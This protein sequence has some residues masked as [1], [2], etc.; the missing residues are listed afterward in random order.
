MILV[1]NVY[2]A[3]TLKIGII[4]SDKGD[5][6]QFDTIHLKA[7]QLAVDNIN[8]KG[9]VKNQQIEIIKFFN[10]STSIGAKSAAIRA[11]EENILV[12]IGP[13]WSSHA[14]AAAKIFQKAKIPMITPLASNSAVTE[15]G[16]YIFRVCFTDNFQSKALASFVKDDIRID[17]IVILTNL[18]S[19]YSVGLSKS[20]RNWF[21]KFGGIIDAEI[22]YVHGVTNYYKLAKQLKIINAKAIFLPGYPLDSSSIINE[23]RKIGVK[24]I[25]I[26]S[27]GWGDI[28]EF[29]SGKKINGSYYSGSWHPSINSPESNEFVRLYKAKYGDFTS[30]GVALYYDTINIILKAIEMSRVVDSV[31]IKSSLNRITNYKGVTGNISFD[32]N[33]NTANSIAIFQFLEGKSIFLK[34]IKP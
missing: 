30:K 33:G 7:V 27:D 20:F 5:S 8:K 19:L 31:S 34:T 6:K 29:Y 15:V 21:I 4:I 1:A 12:A 32:S 16:D 24:S 13:A 25:F 28:M 11:V 14:M 2:S 17:N 22:D 3:T 23:S 26:G 18:E 9:G 10:N